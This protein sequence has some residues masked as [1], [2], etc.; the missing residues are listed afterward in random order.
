MKLLFAIA[1]F[2]LLLALLVWNLGPRA[3]I[4][5]A[6]SKIPQ[7]PDDL[8]TYLANRESKTS[9]PLKEGVE[10]TIIWAHPDKR[11]TERSIVYLH[12]FSSS[13]REMSPVFETIAQHLG[14]NIFLTRF[15]GHGSKNGEMLK[16]VGIDDWM[17]DSLE[18]RAIGE[19]IGEKVIIAGTSHGGLLATWVSTA[20]GFTSE[21]EAVILVSPNFA[22]YDKRSVMLNKPWAKQILPI[23]FGRH[24]EWDPQNSG[25]EH[26]W[27]TI[28]PVEA[29][30]P[31]MAQVNYITASAPQRLNFPTLVLYSPEDITVDPNRITSCF[32]R[33]PTDTKQLIVVENVRDSMQHI[34]AGDVLSPE[35][36][37]PVISDI[38]HFLASIGI[39][40]T[41]E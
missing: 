4:K 36:N 33:F 39:S 30:F 40:S 41:N 27:N 29:L 31:M 17:F 25:H 7:I 16:E 37:E 19:K 8:D 5:A 14:A 22:P 26:Y 10:A 12:G 18:A 38:E 28:Y 23:F 9:M 24:R 20:S 6:P 2:V 34:L 15:Q 11:K 21:P 35:T 1:V 3:I 32:K 13:R